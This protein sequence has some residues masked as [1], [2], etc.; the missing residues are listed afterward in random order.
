LNIKIKN[1]VLFLLGINILALGT[2][3]FSVGNLGFSALVSVPQVFSVITKITLGQ[4]TMIF[5]AILII[6]E[7]ILIRKIK[8][9]IIL[10]MILSFVFGVI[11]DFYGITLGLKSIHL[12][13]LWEQ[14]AMTLLAIVF[15]SLGIFIMVKARFILIPPDGL[16]NVISSKYTIKFG[17]VKLGFDAFNIILSLLVSILI[18][19]HIEGVG[20]GTALAVIMVGQLINLWES[21]Y[22]D[23]N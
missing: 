17:F 8:L 3:F 1:I 16:V 18:L 12:A 23:S 9:Q 10:Q 21:L 2:V 6:M 19:H 7:I 22:K 11:V 14:L 13:F 20:I 4:A 5:F 15:T